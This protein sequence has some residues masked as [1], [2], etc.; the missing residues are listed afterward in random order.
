MLNMTY[1]SHESLES[2]YD[3]IYD[4]G[5]LAVA[6]NPFT[7]ISLYSQLWYILFNQH[8]EVPG[9]ELGPVKLLPSYSYGLTPFGPEN[10]YQIY[11]WG[12][13]ISPG[14]LYF[15]QGN[16]SSNNYLGFG[17]EGE[18]L[19][20][21]S[22]GSIGLKADFWIQPKLVKQSLSP[23]TKVK[24]TERGYFFKTFHLEPINSG[25]PNLSSY[26]S[27]FGGSFSLIYKYVSNKTVFQDFLNHTWL[28]VG[29]KTE[30]FTPGEPLRASPIIRLGLGYLF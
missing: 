18:S 10:I 28:Q 7:Y 27:R 9:I 12:K 11:Y 30:G 2:Q 14:Y 1:P 21:T 16:Y 4:R 23:N 8:V 5:S 13:E 26:R 22:L 6:L 29:Y 24:T 25:L 3:K 20:K 17:Y 15:K 19:L